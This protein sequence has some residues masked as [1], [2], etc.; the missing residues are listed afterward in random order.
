MSA[1]VLSMMEALA[2]SAALVDVA[3]EAGVSPDVARR[4]AASLAAL[5]IAQVV[6]ICTAAHEGRARQRARMQRRSGR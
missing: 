3:A 5:P 2:D 4:V 1:E 6:R